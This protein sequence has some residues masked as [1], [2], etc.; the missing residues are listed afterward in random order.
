LSAAVGW[1]LELG[2]VETGGG[3]FS[4]KKA[5]KALGEWDTSDWLW[6]LLCTFC[7]PGYLVTVCLGWADYQPYEAMSIEAY[8]EAA[9]QL[10][11]NLH[12]FLSGFSGGAASNNRYLVHTHTFLAINL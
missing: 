1:I 2:E 11:L 3:R 5:R 6:Y 12:V 8:W 7:Y 10:W 4:F 9:P